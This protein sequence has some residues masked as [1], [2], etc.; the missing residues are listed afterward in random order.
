MTEP[1]RE[2][3]LHLA[4]RARR[5]VLLPAE[6][7]LLADAV[8]ELTEEMVNAQQDIEHMKLLVAASSEPGAAVRMAA[9]YAERAIENGERAVQAEA[10]IERVRAWIAGEPVTAR[11]E[12]GSGYREALRDITDALD[13]AQQPTTEATHVA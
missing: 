3:L 12:F 10:A 4:N 6:G 1:T 11:S 13:Q 7:V 2:Q 9:Q 5:G 8:A